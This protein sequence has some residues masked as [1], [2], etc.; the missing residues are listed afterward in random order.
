MRLHLFLCAL[1]FH[2]WDALT[3]GSMPDRQCAVCRRVEHYI[4]GIAGEGFYC[5]VY[6]KRE[7]SSVPRDTET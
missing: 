3:I 7:R 2:W 1:G 4:S 5:Q 6:L